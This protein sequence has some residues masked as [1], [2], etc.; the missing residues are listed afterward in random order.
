[1][2]LT[3]LAHIS[4]CHMLVTVF[5]GQH[6]TKYLSTRHI[7]M[8]A[9]WKVKLVPI[10]NILRHMQG[11]HL[12]RATTAKQP[13]GVPRVVPVSTTF[14]GQLSPPSS[15]ILND[16]KDKLVCASTHGSLKLLALSAQPCTIGQ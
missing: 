1:M 9:N 14:V 12:M 15:R 2:I 4:L 11:K 16:F 10:T 5:Q 6:T 7:G 8:R 13:M 3:M